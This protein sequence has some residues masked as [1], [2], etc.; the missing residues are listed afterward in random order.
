MAESEEDDQAV[1]K[2]AMIKRTEGHLRVLSVVDKIG[3]SHPPNLI[4]IR[5]QT[6]RNDSGYWLDT[7]DLES[8]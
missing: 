2:P 1:K 8:F 5:L 3:Q 7:G 6:L 4:A